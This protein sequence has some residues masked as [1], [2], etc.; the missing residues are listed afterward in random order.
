MSDPDVPFD[1]VRPADLAH[2]LAGMSSNPQTLRLGVVSSVNSASGSNRATVTVDDRDI[3]YL[4]SYSPTVNDV[5]AWIEAGQVRV[6]L[7]KLV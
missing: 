6:V 2:V 3:P 1:T 5:V 4:S 7:G